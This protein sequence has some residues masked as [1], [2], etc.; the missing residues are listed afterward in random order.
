[1]TEP[2]PQE[3]KTLVIVKINGIYYFF[4]RIKNQAPSSFSQ[5]SSLIKAYI[6]ENDISLDIMKQTTLVCKG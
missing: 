1:M 4:A 2:Y 6:L 5:R 3:K